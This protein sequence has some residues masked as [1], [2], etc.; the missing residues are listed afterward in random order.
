MILNKISDNLKYYIVKR[1]SKIKIELKEMNFKWLT[2]R[3]N[4]RSLKSIKDY[5]IF[6]KLILM[7]LTM[8]N[9]Q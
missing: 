5:W 9:I 6:K 1:T 7:K 8:R 2:L 3:T 4:F